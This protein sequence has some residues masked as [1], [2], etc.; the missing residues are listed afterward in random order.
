MLAWGAKRQT[1]LGAAKRRKTT[2]PVVASTDSSGSTSAFDPKQAADTAREYMQHQSIAR[3]SVADPEKVN[4]LPGKATA[5]AQTA[6]VRVTAEPVASEAV[7]EQKG[8]GDADAELTARAERVREK[9]WNAGKQKGAQQKALQ[10][11]MKRSEAETSH[12][13]KQEALAKAEAAQKAVEELLA[14][15]EQA[16]HQAAAKK[17]K[18]DRRKAK[19]QQQQEEE[20]LQRQQQQEEEL[21]QRQQQQE[22]EQLQYQQQQEE[23]KHRV[24]QEMRHQQH[25]QEEQKLQQQQKQAK[26]HAQKLQKQ[27]QTLQGQEL[28]QKLQPQVQELHEDQTQQEWQEQQQQQQKQQKKQQRSVEQPPLQVHTQQVGHA[29]SGSSPGTPAN[30]VTALKGSAAGQTEP[31]LSPEPMHVKQSN[32]LAS[33]HR[34]TVS[35]VRFDHAEPGHGVGGQHEGWLPTVDHLPVTRPQKRFAAPHHLLCCPI[36]QACYFLL[37]NVLSTLDCRPPAKVACFMCKLCACSVCF[38]MESL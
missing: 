25:L 36:T 24:Q 10:E 2:D 35:T 3:P 11:K 32:G 1:P 19:K 28:Q 37:C 12:A 29:A 33:P 26:Q 38:W 22:E 7:S 31:V 34:Q 21:L 9:L 27:A 4:Q 15:E 14:E 8:T 17:A 6:P 20:L 5:A 18:K 16:A 30:M 23:E 13:T